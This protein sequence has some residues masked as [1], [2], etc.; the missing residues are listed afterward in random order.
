MKNIFEHSS[1]HW[2]KYDGYEIRPAADGVLYITPN[3]NAEP[4]VYDPLINAKAMVIDALNVG[5]LCM[6]RESEDEIRKGVTDFVSAY[7][8]L[9]LMTALPTTPKFVDYEA[10]YLPKNH[11][12][13]D[14][15]MTTEAYLSLFFPFDKPDFHKRGI[16]SNINITDRK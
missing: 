9:G 15:A 3:D 10:V 4:R 13:K 6:N 8:L 14:E 1:S 12:I 2:V 7:G 5:L 16:E 11:F